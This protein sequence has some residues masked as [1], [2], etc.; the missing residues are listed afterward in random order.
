M[1][2]QVF[3]C[4][5][6]AL[7]L[8]PAALASQ[9]DHGF[10]QVDFAV[11][12]V[13]LDAEPRT[14]DGF[15]LLSSKPAIPGKNADIGDTDQSGAVDNL[16]Q[17]SRTDVTFPPSLAKSGLR[18]LSGPEIHDAVERASNPP[19][20]GKPSSEAWW[21]FHSAF[22][23]SVGLMSVSLP[24]YTASGDIAVVYT[25]FQ[26]G[27]LCGNGEY[28]YLH[29]VKGRWQILVRLRVWVS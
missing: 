6:I 16:I 29:R 8:S 20:G 22:P 18:I 27:A 9:D 5:L 28:I 14:Q 23:G 1:R 4:F 24:G 15:I 7:L 2:I 17:R 25:S 12:K 3:V 11:L 21:R 19:A 10:T 13:V 26:C